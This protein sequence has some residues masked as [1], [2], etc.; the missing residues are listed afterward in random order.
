MS[1][2]EQIAILRAVKDGHKIEAKHKD[3]E[4]GWHEWSDDC[5]FNM[6]NY[7]I[8]PEPREWYIVDRHDGH[9][10]VAIKTS[11]HFPR[12]WTVLALAREDLSATPKTQL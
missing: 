3:G 5:D 4:S 6:Y 12:D 9:V 1:I 8:V 2:D 11:L 7:R 10:P